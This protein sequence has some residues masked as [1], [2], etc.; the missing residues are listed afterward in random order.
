M[1]AGTFFLSNFE[2]VYLTLCAWVSILA[3]LHLTIAGE[4]CV[5]H[6]SIDGIVLPRHPRHR[7]YQPVEALV[8]LAK[9]NAQNRHQ[10]PWVV[11]K[12][13]TFLS[14]HLNSAHRGSRAWLWVQVA[15]GGNCTLA[16]LSLSAR[17]CGLCTRGPEHEGPFRSAI[18]RR[19][20]C[21]HVGTLPSLHHHQESTSI[22]TSLVVTHQTVRQ[23]HQEATASNIQRAA[24][25]T[26][27]SGIPRFTPKGHKSQHLFWP[28]APD[29]MRARRALGR[30][31]LVP[32]KK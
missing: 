14:A 29:F 30:R 10:K 25:G 26:R 27:F 24:G 3:S 23:I 8:L 18:K 15:P 1:R 16:L 12:F 19:L 28:Q 9:T 17:R 31:R 4:P 5:R 11:H 6:L 13:K 22:E 32:L 21:T 7:L 20:R 2:G